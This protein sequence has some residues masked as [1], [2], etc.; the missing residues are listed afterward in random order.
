MHL[1]RD[2][3]FAS[4]PR[5][6]HIEHAEFV[7]RAVAVFGGPQHAVRQRLVTLKVKHRIHDVLHDFGASNRTVLVDMA[8]DERGD[9][10][11][12][13]HGLSS[14]AALSFTWLTVPDDDEISVQRIVWMESMTTRSGFIRFDQAADLVH[15][16][17]GGQRDV[18][19]R[20][21]FSRAARSFTCRTD[22]SPVTYEHIAGLA[23]L[24]AELQKNR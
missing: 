10:Q 13:R 22:S 15:V 4:S 23:D 11:P 21:S 17:L 16:A 18:L 2:S 5:P 9:L 20:A 8:D 3:R 1:G 12:F 6:G 24:A 19:L 7:R 14:R